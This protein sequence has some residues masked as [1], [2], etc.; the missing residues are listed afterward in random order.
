MYHHPP[1]RDNVTARHGLPNLRS[2][3]H[4]SHNREGGQEVHKGHVVALENIYISEEIMMKMTINLHVSHFDNNFENGSNKELF[5]S[6]FLL[7]FEA[8]TYA[9]T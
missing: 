2:W 7:F 9:C 8:S 6:E 5:T 4:F 3:L 1:H